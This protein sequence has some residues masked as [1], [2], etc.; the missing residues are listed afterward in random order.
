[1][2]WFHAGITC[3]FLGACVT[4]GPVTKT[5][6]K[7]S[8]RAPVNLLGDAA[9]A[10]NASAIEAEAEAYRSR[11]RPR[12][13]S[14]SLTA[15]AANVPPGA[16]LPLIIYFHGCAGIIRAAIGHLGLLAELDDFAE[17]APDSFARKR[18]E[19]CFSNFTVDLSISG[20]VRNMRLSE[21]DHVMKQVAKLPWVDQNNIFLI[22][23]SQGG[24]P[25]SAYDGG[26]KVRG[27]IILNGYCSDLWGDGMSSDEAL[28]TFDSGQ[29]AWFRNFPSDCRAFVLRHGGTSIFEAEATTH[30]LALNHWPKVKAFLMDNRR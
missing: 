28:L 15:L 12:Y 20:D 22:G 18:P 24:G 29:D 7:A 17:I 23:H 10:I 11:H 4:T 26:V 25:V 14:D 5:F 16:K 6:E 9:V 27:R 1:M 3:I 2:R 8:V 19:Y 30:N 13:S 21:L